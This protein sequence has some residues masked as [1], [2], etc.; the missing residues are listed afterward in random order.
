[1]SAHPLRVVLLWHMHQPE[2]RDPIGGAFLSPWTY[3]HAL[4]DYSDM[5][6]HVEAHPGARAVFN[7][8]PVLVAQ[9]AEYARRLRA[10]QGTP[11]GDE[12]LDTLRHPVIALDEGHRRALT[13]ECLRAD[14]RR[15]V[16]RFEPYRQLADLATFALA[17]REA[18]DYLNDAFLGDLLVWYH[19][20]WLGES[21][22]RGDARAVALMAKQRHF[23]ARDRA[24]LLD[25]IAD[26][27]DGLLARYR[28]LAASGQVELITSPFT[29]PILPLLIDF[30]SAREALPELALPSAAA[31]P[32]GAERARWHLQQARE[33]HAAHFATE[34]LG[35]WPSESALCAASA[36]LIGEA[37]FRWAA[38]SQ[39]VLTRS[40][41]PAQRSSE[42]VHRPYRL[43]RSGPA[44][45]FRDDE[46]SDLIGFTYKDWNPAD[47]V[48][49]LLHRLRAIAAEPD[50][51]PGRVVLIALDGENAWEHYPENAFAFL[52][53]LYR[54]FSSEPWLRLTTPAECLREEEVEVRHLDRLVAGSWVYADLAT[55]IGHPDKNRAWDMLVDAKRAY[56]GC[57]EAV[58]EA[59]RQLAV[60]EGSDW[61]WWPGDYNPETH[62]AEFERLYRVQL[63]ALYRLLGRDPPEY[64]AHIFSHGT[65]VP[66]EYAVLRP[67]R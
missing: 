57:A 5:A 26:T 24:A 54:T 6:A 17:Q 64:L 62:V 34:P 12:L 19:L 39:G 65:A 60:C 52:E 50:G 13:R 23:N 11:I 7:F 43:N 2:Y 3:L 51:G 1:V 33:S 28:A 42:H 29:H 25:L 8:T 16:E 66:D 58:P 47:A 38:S 10:G 44:I 48:A 18:F 21:V 49:D 53:C 63:A 22:R 31:Y 59:E 36:D 67:L 30:A 46:L 40:L 9:I 32:G 41:H 45:F 55:W 20:A 61:F 37:G 35:C 27:L 14:R 56:D 4:K 15:M